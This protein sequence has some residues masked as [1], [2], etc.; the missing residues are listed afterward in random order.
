MSIIS[1]TR[2]P[3]TSVPYDVL[4]EIFLQCLPEDRL[5]NTYWQPSVETAPLLLCHICSSWRAA[6]LE[7]PFLWTHLHIPLS[8]IWDDEGN[9]LVRNPAALKRD[10]EFM[11]WWR[12]NHRSM[13]PFLR[14]SIYRISRTSGID[15]HAN[16]LDSEAADFLLDYMLSAH[17][18]DVGLFYPYLIR[19]GVERGLRILLPKL[20]TLVSN[21]I[22]LF[23]YD[24]EDVDDGTYY[25]S[26]KLELPPQIPATVRRLSIQYTI[27]RED[28]IKNLDNWSTLTHLAINVILSP[29]IWFSILRALKDLQWGSFTVKTVDTVE[30][31]PQKISLSSLRTLT[32]NCITVGVSPEFPLSTLFTN[33][34]LPA[35]RTLSLIC[36]AAAWRDSR[37]ATELQHV[38]E[39]AP[40]VTQLFLGPRF[41]CY[42]KDAILPTSVDQGVPP[43]SLHAPHLCHLTLELECRDDDDDVAMIVKGFIKHHFLSKHWLDLRSPANKIRKITIVVKAM[44]WDVDSQFE[45]ILKALLLWNIQKFFKRKLNRSFEVATEAQHSIDLTW[46][47]WRSTV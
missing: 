42:A 41:L 43:L 28:F 32:V 24:D 23:A 20:H 33:L 30:S 22:C 9:P 17:Y 1:I 8:V 13:A 27:L 39:A 44:K 47:A 16:H 25:V 18:L 3:F 2:S 10:I 11:K 35:L 14:F 6:A 19:H 37:A 34:H 7:N 29:D 40:A 5:D 45:N 4:Q 21:A 15:I 31:T 12:T 26:D 38:F 36:D 46:R